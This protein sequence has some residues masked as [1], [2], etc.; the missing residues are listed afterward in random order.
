[1]A[2]NSVKISEGHQQRLS[3]PVTLPHTT[4]TTPISISDYLW[5]NLT[6]SP[7]PTTDPEQEWTDV[8]AT[9]LKAS[10]MI[11]III[12]AILGNLL[13]IVSVMRTP[14]TSYHNE[15]FRGVF[16]FCGHVGGHA[17]HDV[18]C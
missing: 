5:E 15:L 13:V 14:E 16:S 7:L 12:A 9:I 1:M 8:L 3:L 10:A 17:G 2:S 18:Q 6:T 4:L 11:F